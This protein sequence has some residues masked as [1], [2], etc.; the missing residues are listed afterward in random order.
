VDLAVLTLALVAGAVAAFN[1]CGFALLPAY[2]SLLVAAPGEAGAGTQLAAVGRAA[3][4]T[5]GMTTGF[6]AV[7]GVF[8][9][10]VTP[11]ALSVE[12][13]LPVVTLV[14]G[15]A[16]LGAGGWLLAGRSLPAPRLLRKGRAP[17][18]P[19]T[20]QVGYG[21]AFAL[22]SLS[23]TVAPF[24]AVTAGAVRAGGTPALLATYLAYA[25]GMG[26]VVGVL[27]L[28][29]ATASSGLTAR[30][31]RTAPYVARASGALLVLAGA[32]VAWYGWFELRVLAGSATGDPVVDAATGVQSA[33]ARAVADVGA[34]GVAA[35][36]LGVLAVAAVAAAL[37][38]RRARTD[39]ATADRVAAELVDAEA[40]RP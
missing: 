20:S 16:L 1:P 3:R 5:A 36:A 2:L 7:F 8:G 6:V 22:A 34:A 12:R 26:A 17:G 31:R 29:A 23:C 19:W 35:V 40:R 24:L 4:F 10:V 11:L 27:S 13:Y 39:A 14:V 25:V 9:L 32:Y 18:T 21:V 28:A 15:A 38:R 30:M 33:L 37:W